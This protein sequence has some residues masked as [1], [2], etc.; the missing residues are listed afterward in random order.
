MMRLVGVLT[1]LAVTCCGP[2]Q[3]KCGK[4]RWP[5]KTGTDDASQIDMSTLVATR[6]RVSAIVSDARTPGEGLWIS[7][8]RPVAKRWYASS[9]PQR[10]GTRTSIT[11]FA[12]RRSWYSGG[13]SNHL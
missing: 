9:S 4:E 13:A 5:M 6:I 11:L 10:Q 1:L 7:A 8:L 3:A 12:T 2:V